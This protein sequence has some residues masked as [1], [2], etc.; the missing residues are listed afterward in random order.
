MSAPTETPRSGGRSSPYGGLR[1]GG[2]DGGD[3]NNALN[4]LVTPL[5]WGIGS[6]TKTVRGFLGSPSFENEA[7][8][9][10]ATPSAAPTNF[11]PAVN[12]PRENQGGSSTANLLDALKQRNNLT[13]EET[14]AVISLLQRQGASAEI[15]AF[16]AYAPSTSAM[17]P[18][19]PVGLFQ[20]PSSAG[21]TAAR[22]PGPAGETAF[23]NI[24]S[25]LRRANEEKR[26]A[27]LSLPHARG[28]S[29]YPALGYGG[30]RGARSLYGAHDGRMPPSLLGAP[31]GQGHAE[32][33][34]RAARG[35]GTT[36]RAGAR[37][38]G[39]NSPPTASG[40]GMDWRAPS[41]EPGL[42]SPGMK[43]TRDTAE[44]D[45]DAREIGRSTVARLTGHGDAPRAAPGG[46]PAGPPARSA[47]PAPPATNLAAAAVT[48]ATPRRILQTLD[49]LAG[50]KSGGLAVP[51]KNVYRRNIFRA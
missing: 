51:Q 9:S 44:M 39:P 42:L 10:A 43:R 46:L 14:Q 48:P 49:R 38:G 41:S 22:S 47:L 2:G 8:P 34:G 6:L 29:R 11:E 15:A 19:A 40:I 4:K 12:A 7:V 31:A 33:A 18:P 23:S 17:P 30:A 24:H 36:V 45:M 32:T 25:Y 13:R 35:F 20:T 5:R 16:D 28:A 3:S 21:P 37:Y 26:R 50:Q 27:P 1:P